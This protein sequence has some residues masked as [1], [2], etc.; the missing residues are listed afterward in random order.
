MLMPPLATTGGSVRFSST[1]R[2]AKMPRSSGTKPMPVRAIL[3]SGTRMIEFCSKKTS[4]LRL[5]MMPMMARSV[6]VFPTP[7]RPSSVT[8]SPGKM[9]RSTPCRA[10]LSPY[11]ASRLRTLSCAGAPLPRSAVFG[12]TD[13]S[14][15]VI[16]RPHIRLAHARIGAYSGAVA[17][18][19]DFAALQDGDL[20]ADIGDDFEI[21]FDHQQRAVARH[22]LDQ[23]GHVLDVLL[24]HSG[25][26]FVEEQY[27]WPQRQRGCDFQS[28]L[29]PVG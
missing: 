16:F 9:S 23:L 3:C 28:A 12:A 7:L 13:V 11:Q 19:Q 6:V 8:V 5:R 17:P 21:M 18:R 24:A 20:I 22:G 1:V 25:Q 2:L 14:V 29:A 4:P 26:R 27:T 15:P 10:W